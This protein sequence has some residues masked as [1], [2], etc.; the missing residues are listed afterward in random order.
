MLV[1]NDGHAILVT[2]AS[3]IFP[4]RYSLWLSN[5]AQKVCT[6]NWVAPEYVDQRYWND[7]IGKLFDS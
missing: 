1:S 5:S 7:G 2:L 4:E 3:P 6:L